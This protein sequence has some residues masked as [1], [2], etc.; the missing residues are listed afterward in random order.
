M[1]QCPNKIVSVRYFLLNRIKL[2]AINNLKELSNESENLPKKD[3]DIIHNL[4]NSQGIQQFSFCKIILF[5]NK[6]LPL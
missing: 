4:S 1:N 5:Y 3:K 6:I 2:I